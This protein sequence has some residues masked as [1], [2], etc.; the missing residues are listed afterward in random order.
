MSEKIKELADL[1][2]VWTSCYDED[3]CEVDP[4]KFAKLILEEA[5]AIVRDELAYQG[6]WNRA[7]DVVKKVNEHFGV[8]YE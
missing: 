8:D 6:E 5:M 1:A 4:E 2:E 7:D 3:R